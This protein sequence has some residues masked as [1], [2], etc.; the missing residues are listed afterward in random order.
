MVAPA[1]GDDARLPGLLLPLR[2]WELP[3]SPFARRSQFN[4]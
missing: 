1:V 2:P 4:E 3:E